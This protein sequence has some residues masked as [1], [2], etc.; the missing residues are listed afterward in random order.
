MASDIITESLLS[1]ADNLTELYEE[2]GLKIPCEP[3]HTKT[4]YLLNH[5]LLKDLRANTSK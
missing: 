1:E 5:P 3:R 4:G 2:S